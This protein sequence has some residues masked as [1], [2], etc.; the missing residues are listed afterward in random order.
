MSKYG[1][2]NG[3]N[4]RV[5]SEQS[6]LLRSNGND[7]QGSDSTLLDPEVHEDDGLEQKP[8]ISTRR[9]VLIAL[10]LWGLLFLQGKFDITLH[11]LK[12]KC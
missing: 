4:Q 12:S 8:R 6:P 2:K 3:Q 11:I 9:G 1:I 7:D 10:L 5:V